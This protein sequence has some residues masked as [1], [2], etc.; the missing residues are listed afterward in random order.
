MNSSKVNKIIELYNNIGYLKLSE[1]LNE[2][3]YDI[4]KVVK[5]YGLDNYLYDEDLA[6]NVINDYQNKTSFKKIEEKYSISIDC[7]IKILQK[8]NIV[9]GKRRW[10]QEEDYIIKKYYK[11]VPFDDIL[12][13]LPHRNVTSIRRYASRNNITT[14]IELWTKEQEEYLLENMF[15]IPTNKI[16]SY[17]GK[18]NY[19]CLSKYKILIRK[20]KGN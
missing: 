16:A 2:E 12:G 13:M 7:I 5:K 14:K 15:N 9:G 3:V 11:N 19:A 8:N 10:T 1:L 20:E 6:N 17:L 18:T 4:Y